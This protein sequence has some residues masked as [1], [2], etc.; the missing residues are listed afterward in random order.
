MPLSHQPA[1]ANCALLVIDMQYD[2]MPGGQL[3]VADGDA[4][5]PLVNRLGE[6]FTQVI[7]TQDW[8]PAGHISFASSH[9]GRKPFESIPLPYGPQTLWPDHCIQGS[10]GAQLHA[11]LDLPHARLILRKGCNAQIDSYS[12]FLEADRTTTTGL[13][14]YLRERGIDTL[15]VVGLALDFCVSWSAQDAR[16][17]GFNTYVIEDACRAI[18]MNGSLENAWQAML[19]SGVKRVRSEDVLTP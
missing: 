13:A 10:T 7:V 19:A 8:H 18:D 12:A 14:G 11:D 2:F 15:F 6:R 4:V 3:A 17:A 1:A 16:K 5:L 9:P